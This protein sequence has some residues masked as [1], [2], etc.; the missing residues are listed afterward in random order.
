MLL[1]YPR[2]PVL[3]CRIHSLRSQR[4]ASPGG[5]AMGD[6]GVQGANR[7]PSEAATRGQRANANVCA[8]RAAGNGA[9]VSLPCRQPCQNTTMLNNACHS[10]AWVIRRE[11]C[12][13]PSAVVSQVQPDH[14]LFQR[15]DSYYLLVRWFMFGQ[16]LNVFIAPNNMELN[17]NN[18][19]NKG[20]N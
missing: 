13:R 6:H 7:N 19:L 10:N 5:N 9:L 14:L 1:I 3:W 20:K 4:P 16:Q 18:S 2:Q 17:C 8:P 15:F 11:R 12:L